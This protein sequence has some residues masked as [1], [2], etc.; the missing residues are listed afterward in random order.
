M[1]SGT[2]IYVGS[3]G[4]S[5][6]QVFQLAESGGLEFLAAVPLPDVAEPGPSTPLAV[7][8]DRRFLYCGI[9]SQ[10]FQV[11]A[12]A[13]DRSS[14]EL[15]PLGNA[16]L[17][18]SMAYI[19]TDATGRWLFSASYG[20]SRVAVNPIGP[21]GRV[22]APQQVVP[23]EPK[24]HAIIPD[25]ANQ[26]VYSTSLGGDLIH[27]FHFDAETGALEG[28]E[29]AVRV[30]AGAGPRHLRFHPNGRVLFLLN[31]L[32]ASLDVL[33]VEGADAPLRSLQT[34]S[35]L[36]PG[37][38]GKPW[39]ADLQ[40]T[41]DGRL[42]YASER[43]SSSLLAYRIDPA[44]GRLTPLGATPTETQPRGFAIDPSGRVLIA[45]GEVSHHVSSYR[46]EPESGALTALSRVE[47]GEGPNW[48]E[49]VR[50]G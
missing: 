41:P 21:D 23:T 32:N 24:A 44:T 40:V 48:V 18:D 2:V 3:A 7:S 15:T 5:E 19:A 12:F 31:E 35:A 33:A 6:I 38:S 46:I 34:I 9:R 13:I 8:S 47:A 28:G 20:G 25:P 10:P 37:F 1:A 14:G 22:G 36:P 16:P 4:T 30:A 43:T 50:L 45:A 27:R 49:V 29:P 42:L 11:A 17:A 26:F 39:G